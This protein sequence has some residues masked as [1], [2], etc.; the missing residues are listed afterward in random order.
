MPIVHL[1]NIR[2]INTGAP[3]VTFC[4]ISQ[5]LWYTGGWIVA[6]AGENGCQ[7]SGLRTQ[8]GGNHEW[9]TLSS[10]FK[11]LLERCV[12]LPFYNLFPTAALMG[13]ET[14]LRGKVLPHNSHS[15][16]PSPE[17]DC[18]DLGI[19]NTKI[20]IIYVQER[21]GNIYKR[22]D[23]RRYQSIDELHCVEPDRMCCNACD[24]RSHI[25]STARS[26][27]QRVWP[28]VTPLLRP[29]NGSTVIITAG[30]RAF[31]GRRNTLKI[32]KSINNL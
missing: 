27:F 10:F 12:V 2:S 9:L 8:V 18:W 31:M 7:G 19:V 21:E 23:V 22:R 28:F 26:M 13:T 14:P 6:A 15:A 17:S 16:T 4:G 30:K 1:H 29:I 11:T 25:K 5:I 24:Q 20:E 32:H 3:C